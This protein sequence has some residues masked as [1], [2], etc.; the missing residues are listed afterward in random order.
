MFIKPKIDKKDSIFYP[1]TYS[2]SLQ[3]V[4]TFRIDGY[5]F[6]TVSHRTYQQTHFN[7]SRDCSGTCRREVL[8]KRLMQSDYCTVLY[9]YI[10][11]FGDFFVENF[12]LFQC[13]LFNG[14][15]NT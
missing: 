15:S 3:F 9:Q 7:V 14:M 11:E 13:K 4:C 1:W 8:G 6:W 5:A 10:L 2:Q 12:G